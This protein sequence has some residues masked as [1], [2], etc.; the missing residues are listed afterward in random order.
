MQF[1]GS[2]SDFHPLLMVMA[3]PA[4]GLGRKRN[5]C[6]QL[7]IMSKNLYAEPH[8]VGQLENNSCEGFR[9]I[10]GLLQPHAISSPFFSDSFLRI[11]S[12]SL[13]QCSLSLL[14]CLISSI[15]HKFLMKRVCQRLA[16]ERGF[17]EKYDI[18]PAAFQAFH[19]CNPL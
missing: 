1:L 12:S 19:C 14:I 11:L 3:N 17:R 9:Q 5:N 13:S 6:Y 8:L 16:H 18:D 2:L 10:R 4:F 7:F 15:S